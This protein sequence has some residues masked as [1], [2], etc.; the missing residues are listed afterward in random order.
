MSYLEINLG[1]LRSRL[2]DLRSGRGQAIFDDELA[3][4]EAVVERSELGSAVSQALVVPY[5]DAGDLIDT[6]LLGYRHDQAGE[7]TKGQ[8][9]PYSEGGS[10]RGPM[11]SVEYQGFPGKPMGP[12]IPVTDDI[13]AYGIERGPIDLD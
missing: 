12:P 7:T 9:T 5:P 6:V 13:D 4:L 11:R 8:P 10:A 1:H 2:A 3:M